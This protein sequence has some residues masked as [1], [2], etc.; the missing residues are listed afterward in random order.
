MMTFVR[1]DFVHFFPPHTM[2]VDAANGA[3][4]ERE[5]EGKKGQKE[6]SAVDQFSAE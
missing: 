6:G 1:V 3:T 2:Q 4:P 5:R